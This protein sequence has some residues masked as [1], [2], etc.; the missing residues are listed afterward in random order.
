VD[1]GRYI[2]PSS[3]L[4]HSREPGLSRGP[5]VGEDPLDGAL[6]EL[7]RSSAAVNQPLTGEECRQR[8]FVLRQVDESP[9][10]RAHAL[11]GTKHTVDRNH[12]V[13][14]PPIRV[15]DRW[16][17]VASALRLRAPSELLSRRQSRGTDPWPSSSCRC[18]RGSRSPATSAV[19]PVPPSLP[20]AARRR[21]GVAVARSGR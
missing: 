16:L 9:V 14:P 20:C 4:F 3:L 21:P 15:M 1:N 5:R 10:R 2:S 11:V 7:R 12:S 13:D 18:R 17:R 19:L 6:R 8:R